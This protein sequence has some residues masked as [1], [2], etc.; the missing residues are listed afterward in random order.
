MSSIPGNVQ[1]AGALYFIHDVNL[2]LENFK[3]TQFDCLA[4]STSG[5]SKPDIKY[6][7]TGETVLILEYK[8]A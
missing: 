1:R 4:E 2:I 8:R 6:V 7:V 3:F 5:S